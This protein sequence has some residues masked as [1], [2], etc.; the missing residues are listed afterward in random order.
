MQVLVLTGL[1]NP[2]STYLHC[3]ELC[4]FS[5]Y[6]F[7]TPC[8]LQSR[9]TKRE[10]SLEVPQKEPTVHIFASLVSVVQTKQQ[11]DRVNTLRENINLCFNFTQITQ[12]DDGPDVE[13]T[14]KTLKII[15]RHVRK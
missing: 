1:Q 4:I 15:F 13:I 10:R 8:T 9:N 11:C 2:Y 5:N 7:R 12:I 6:L 14:H 3:N